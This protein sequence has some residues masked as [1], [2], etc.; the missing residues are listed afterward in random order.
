VFTRLDRW[1]RASLWAI[2]ASGGS[3]CWILERI[4]T[5]LGWFGYYGHLDWENYLDVWRPQD[6]PVR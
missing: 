3:P 6:H 4:D 2:P 1:D 5:A